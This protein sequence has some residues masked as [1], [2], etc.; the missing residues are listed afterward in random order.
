MANETTAPAAPAAPQAPSTPENNAPN[1]AQST[2]NTGDNVQAAVQDAAAT[3]TDPKATPTEKKAA[4]KMLKQL[5]YKYNGREFTEN[6]PYEIPDTPEAIEYT[7]NQIQLSKMAHQKAQ[8]SAAIQ[9]DLIAFIDDLKAGG[10]RAKKALKDP[11]IDMDL[12]KLAAEII[13]EEIENSKKSPEQLE[14]EK[15]RQELKD[16]KEKQ[17][18]EAKDREQ[19]EQERMT[20]K[21]AEEY[22]IQITAA[23]EGNKIPKSPAA[24]KKII[25]YMELA[26]EAGKDVTINDIIPVIR[27]ELQSDFREHVAALPDDGLEEFMGKELV[28]RLRKKAVAKVKNPASKNPAVQAAA[29]APSTGTESKKTEEPVKKMNYRDFFKM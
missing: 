14:L 26:V 8:E 15:Y 2:G 19:T 25:S 24:I 13:E 20:E 9:K 28:D 21:F 4:Q 1:E 12:K 27:D 17:E 29:K 10:A 16:L 6:L 22:D 11:A 18:K 7:R 5:K 23:L 3:L